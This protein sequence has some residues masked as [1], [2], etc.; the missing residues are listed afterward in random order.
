MVR[1]RN[2]AVKATALFK[3]LALGKSKECGTEEGERLCTD[4][5]DSSEDEVDH[6]VELM[7]WIL[8]LYL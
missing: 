5:Q 1:A 2:L 8:N 3:R 4:F 6:E 7:A